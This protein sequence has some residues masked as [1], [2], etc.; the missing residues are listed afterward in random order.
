MAEK[1]EKPQALT[2][3]GLNLSP[4]QKQMLAEI[5]PAE[6]IKERPIRGGQAARYVEA[7]FVVAKLNDI[8]GPL[9]WDFVILAR[10]ETD[11]ALDKRASGEVWVEGRIEIIDHKNG[12]RVGKSQY[13]QHP[14]YPGVPTGD[15]YKAAA[16]DALKKCASLL[17]IALDVYWQSMNQEEGID[18]S[19]KKPVAGKGGGNELSA[20]EMYQKARA[21]ILGAKN[22]ALL[23]QYRERIES[24]KVYGLDPK[25]KLLALI[26]EAIKKL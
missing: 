26:D 22:P 5:T 16:S 2:L 6:F 12:F 19:P 7:G 18:D 4:A 25:K 11:R 21:M 23:K 13:G 10:G 15:A 20:A 8:F 24:S 17:G 1:K 3:T 14:I 9:N